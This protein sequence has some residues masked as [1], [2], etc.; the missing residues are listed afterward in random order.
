[1]SENSVQFEEDSTLSGRPTVL[2]SRFQASSHPPA[3]VRLL[4]KL[5]IAKTTTQANYFLL[6]TVILF[7]ALAI[8]IFGNTLGWFTSTRPTYREDIPP[9]VRAHLAPE[10]FESLPSRYDR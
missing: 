2:Y 3:L 6:G 9:E 1:M 4:L 5:G 7:F 10:L 8:Y